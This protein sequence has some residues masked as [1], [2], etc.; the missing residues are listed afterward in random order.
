[1][2]GERAIVVPFIIVEWVAVLTAVRYL[3]IKPGAPQTASSI[4]VRVLGAASILAT[5]LSFLWV[6]RTLHGG[7]P[8]KLEA[9]LVACFVATHLLLVLAIFWMIKRRET[10][11]RKEEK[12]PDR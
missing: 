4:I 7:R 2:L 10:G 6:N 9:P 8:G 11:R 1:M 12:G 3:R 5:F